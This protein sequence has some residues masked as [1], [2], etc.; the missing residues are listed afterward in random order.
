MKKINH[1]S[2]CKKILIHK[3]LETNNNILLYPIFDN[4]DILQEYILEYQNNNFYY[5]LAFFNNNNYTGYFSKIEKKKLSSI[6]NK[7]GDI[8]KFLDDW[9]TNNNCNKEILDLESNAL[10]LLLEKMILKGH[11]NYSLESLEEIKINFFI[12]T[13][14]IKNKVYRFKNKIITNKG[15]SFD[16]FDTLISI[17]S[18]R[19]NLDVRDLMFLKNYYQ[20]EL[21]LLTNKI[22]NK[23]ISY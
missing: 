23:S 11:N 12:S 1:I 18:N 4:L 10:N 22:G 9:L 14:N 21:E 8:K 16:L 13:E 6:I 7:Q 5:L 15:L 17:I 19:H 2:N 3:I 20:D